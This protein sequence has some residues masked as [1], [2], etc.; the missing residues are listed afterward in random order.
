ME[1]SDPE[2]ALVREIQRD[3]SQPLAAL[4]ERA[5]MAQSTVWRKLQEFEAAGLIR[6][7]VA[8]LDPARAGAKLAVVPTVA[9]ADGEP[10]FVCV[11]HG[12]NTWSWSG[13][14]WPGC[15]TSDSTMKRG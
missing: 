14:T 2:R 4:A 8:I 3:A 7:R 1:F 5:G 15:Q 10:I 9:A 13:V 6:G 12:S 11:R